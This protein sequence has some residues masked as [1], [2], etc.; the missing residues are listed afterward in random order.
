[1]Y[2]TPFSLDPFF[3][4]TPFP[5]QDFCTL[6]DSKGVGW[7]DSSVQLWVSVSIIT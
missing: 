6:Q 5:S 7:S 3:P 2:L 1:M 4:V